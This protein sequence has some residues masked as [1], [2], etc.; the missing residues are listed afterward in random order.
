MTRCL[1]HD[2][3]ITEKKSKELAYQVEYDL[4]E[5]IKSVKDP[6]YRNWCRGFLKFII[7]SGKV[8][9][10]KFV[11]GA[12]ATSRLVRISDRI[13]DSELHKMDEIEAAVDTTQESV[14]LPGISYKFD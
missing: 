11:S 14:T 4:F 2:I 12:A 1:F 10:D 7:N 8:F 13:L 5:Y 3:D 6:R 9:F